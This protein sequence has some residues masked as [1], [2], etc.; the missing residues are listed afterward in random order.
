MSTPTE[1]F[2][3]LYEG[4]ADP[5]R[6]STSWYEARKYALTIASLPRQHYRR[7]FEPGCSVGVLTE[8]LAGRCDALVAADVA[9]AAVATASQRVAGLRHV[10]I[11]QLRIPAE[12]PSGGFDL[13]VLSEIGYFLSAEDLQRLVRQSID[14]LDADGALAAVHWRHPVQESPL[15]GDAVHAVIAADARL[16]RVAHHEEPD[17]LIDVFVRSAP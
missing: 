16:E 8:L 2:D 9:A 15:N 13:I 5:W 7:G 12:W 14:S 11:Q 6:M 17:F 3:R 4:S 10:E 1:F